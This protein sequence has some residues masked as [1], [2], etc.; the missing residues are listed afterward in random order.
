MDYL[1]YIAPEMLV[2]VPVLYGMGIVLKQTAL[3]DQFIPAILTVISVLFTT[4][5]IFSE[6]AISTPQEIA[7]ALFTALTQGILIASA[8]VYTNEVVKQAKK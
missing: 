5:Y 4:L 1:N 7:Q 3:K 2:L 6:K 8:S